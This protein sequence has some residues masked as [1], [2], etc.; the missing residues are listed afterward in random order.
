MALA[1]DHDP[2][3]L[4]DDE[5]PLVVARRLIYIQ[6]VVET[7]DPRE[8]QLALRGRLRIRRI[9]RGRLLGRVAILIAA[10]HQQ[11]AGEQ[12]D[13]QTGAPHAPRMADKP[14]SARRLRLST[15]PD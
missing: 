6:R 8:P 4:L 15:R 3:A 12:R 2:A 11:H 14:A 13:H 1:D 5:Q 9:A 10:T 7:P